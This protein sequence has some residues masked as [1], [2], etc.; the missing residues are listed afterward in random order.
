MKSPFGSCG[1]AAAA[2]NRVYG[3]WRDG[4]ALLRAPLLH[5]SDFPERA[6]AVRA[7]VCVRVRV[8]EPLKTNGVSSFLE[9]ISSITPSELF[10]RRYHLRARG[11]N[12]DYKSVDIFT[13][14]AAA[15][16]E[17]IKI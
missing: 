16:A 3:L 4:G 9:S 8:F 17:A 2:V 14:T 10:G 6:A 15:R 11:L 13:M 12:P 7:C 5:V 1:V